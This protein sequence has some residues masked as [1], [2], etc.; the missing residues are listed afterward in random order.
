MA[1]KN[2]R[3]PQKDMERPEQ[4]SSEKKSQYDR[5]K[6]EQTVDSIPLEDLNQEMKEEKEKD[7]TKDSSSSEKKYRDNE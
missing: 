7:K 4:Y 3:K 2:E 1:D 5:F 6:D